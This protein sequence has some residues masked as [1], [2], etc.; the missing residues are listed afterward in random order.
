MRAVRSA[1]NALGATLVFVT[2][3][4]GGL[5]AHMD[6]PAV[7]RAIVARVNV[8]LASALAGHIVIERV[9]SVGPEGVDDVDARVEDPDGKTVL[10]A[11][12]LHACLSTWDR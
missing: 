10:H 5:V 4:A 9:G 8:V 2:A 1:A 6:V 11:W 7:R 3:T 12:G